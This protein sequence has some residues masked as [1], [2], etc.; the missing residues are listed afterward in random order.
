MSKALVIFS[1]GQ[2]STTCLFWAFQKYSKIEAITFHYGQR[3]N[4]EVK[5]S[6]LICKEH[7]IN[8]KIIDV[9]FLNNLVESALLNKKDSVSELKNGLPASYVPN[10]NALFIT[11]AHAYAQTIEADALVTGVCQTDYS[12]YPDCRNSFIER[13]QFAL[14]VGSNKQIG[15]ET[16]LMFLNKSET[17][18]LADKLGR[19]HDVIEKSHTCYEGDHSTF[20][21]WGFGC[22][23]CPACKLREKG[24]NEFKN[25]NV[26]KVSR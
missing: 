4:I 25:Q 15:I 8:Q 11:L 16:P 1:G 23:H 9:S 14:N 18:A 12:G 22:G 10:R 17:F 24:Y 2:D 3:H 7:G 26:G 21:E 6:E 19:L 13:M 20:H 5:Q